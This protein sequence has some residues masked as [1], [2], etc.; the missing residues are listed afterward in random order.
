MD[1][2][3]FQGIYGNCSLIPVE[4]AQNDLTISL[5]THRARTTPAP[6]WAKPEPGSVLGVVVRV[7][8]VTMMVPASCERRACD[9]QQEESGKNELLHAMQISTISIPPYDT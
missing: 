9:N 1:G 8:V 2:S 7:V 4:K 5:L 6:D 3:A